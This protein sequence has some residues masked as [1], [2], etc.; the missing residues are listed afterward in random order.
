[1]PE[2]VPDMGDRSVVLPLLLEQRYQ[3]A[4]GGLAPQSESFP[5]LADPLVVAA[6]QEW[7][8]A[9]VHRPLQ[10]G[11]SAFGIPGA[12]GALGLGE[13]T[14]EERHIQAECGIRRP[15]EAAGIGTEVAI[16]L[17]HRLPELMEELPKVVPGV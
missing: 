11:P 10:A 1:M 12:A 17:R 6:R 5:L 4:Y 14:V 13:G 15:L 8:L 7:A 9:Q 2:P 3:G 16:E